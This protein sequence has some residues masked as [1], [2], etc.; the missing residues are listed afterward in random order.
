MNKIMIIIVAIFLA[1]ALA[2]FV[3]IRVFTARAGVYISTAVPYQNQGKSGKKVLILGDSIAYGTG[4]SA[5]E[6]SVAGLVVANNFPDADVTNLAVNGMRT[7]ELAESI[8]DV[9]GSY[10]LIFIVIGGNDILRPW[11]NISESGK[12]IESIYEK[13]AQHSDNV[14][15]LSTGNFKYTTLFLP[16]LNY[17][18][19]AR[20]VALKDSALN[21]AAQT[22]VNYVNIIDYNER[23]KFTGDMEADD[24]LHLSDR[25][26]QYWYEEI[27]RETSLD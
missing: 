9:E 12:N 21:A 18:F 7:N 13:A 11:I 24:R 4:T 5:P 25:G 3:R 27:K 23:V 19:S 8:Q 1:W 6:K 15:A 20:S 10:D 16:P 26:A 2:N 17:Y 22:G 14:V